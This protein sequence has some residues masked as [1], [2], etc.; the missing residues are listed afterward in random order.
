MNLV[1]QWLVTPAAIALIGI[2]TVLTAACGGGTSSGGSSTPPGTST[3]SSSQPSGQ[4]TPPTPPATPETLP[5]ATTP[6]RGTA[7]SGGQTPVLTTIRTGQHNG[8]DRLVLEFNGGLPAYLVQYVAV[9]SN[10]PKGDAVHL[11][12]TAFLHVVLTGATL[13]D[14]FQGGHRHYTGPKRVIINLP[15]IKEIATAGDFEA[16]L[17]FGIGVAQVEPFS[18][19]TLAGPP[20]LV[21]DVAHPA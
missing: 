19:Q 4:T 12:G 14:A 21:I 17:S 18:V 3:S 1:V 2:S 11:N 15:E 13:D 9:V 7:T 20:R 10:D 16:V 8:F 6:A 5:T